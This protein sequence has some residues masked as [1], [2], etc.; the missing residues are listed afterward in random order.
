MNELSFP[1]LDL[2]HE[3]LRQ[4]RPEREKRLLGSLSENG[5]I[6]PIVVI[7]PGDSGV[8]FVVVDGFKRIRALRRL[9]RETVLATEWD[10]GE[11]EALVLERAMRSGEKESPF[12]QG[13]FLLALHRDFGLGVAEL[14][15]RVDRSEAWVSRRLAL[16][17]E[18]PEPIEERIRRGE[19]GAQAAMRFLVPM[20]RRRP[21]DA[22]RLAEESARNGFTTREIG[23]IYGA[24]REASP[25]IRVRILEDPKLFLRSRRE[26]DEASP[27]ARDAGEE[28]LRDLEM[29][30]SLL[31]RADRKFRK[32]HKEIA[33]EESERIESCLEAARREIDELE[34]R[35]D[36]ERANAIDGTANGNSGTDGERDRAARDLAV[37]GPLPR[38]DPQGPPVGREGAP[39]AGAPGAGN[40]S[41]PGDRRPPPGLP[42]KPGAGPRGAP[43]EGNRDVLPV[44]DGILPP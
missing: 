2:R 7:R 18:L 12:E 41:P 29:A 9:G 22:L 27:A 6:S 25:S 40:R 3:A 43:G 19:I 34:T 35:I 44:A 16:V 23:E 15:R 36:K 38:V 10:V 14:A 17:R 1:Q 4:R 8:R 24:W 31:R 37:D 33:A 32:G 5:Q 11:A 42:G 39:R 13:W 21:S 26:M 30:V 20:A 28:C